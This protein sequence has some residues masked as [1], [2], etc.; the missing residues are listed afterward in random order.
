[1]DHITQMIFGC[2]D[3]L[4]CG[5]DLEL[6]GRFGDSP[7]D[8]LELGGYRIDWEVVDHEPLDHY[9][10]TLRCKVGSMEATKEN[11]ALVASITNWL[12]VVNAIPSG[13]NTFDVFFC[14]D[15]VVSGNLAIDTRALAYALDAIVGAAKVSENYF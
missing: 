10:L 3:K 2:A 7:E 11:Y 13:P 9:L 12:V 5:F 8:F 4:K 6:V 1:M 14:S 15:L